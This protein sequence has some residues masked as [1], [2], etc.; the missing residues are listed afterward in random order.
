MKINYKGYEIT[1]SDYNN[2][3]MIRKNGKMIMHI[4]ATEK[5]TVEELKM[6]I[7][8]YIED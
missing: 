3:I 7:N 2:H 5:Y 8:F 6:I 1:Q 4:S